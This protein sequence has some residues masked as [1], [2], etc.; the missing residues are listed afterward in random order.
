MFA[1]VTTMYIRPE[2]LDKAT[3]IFENSVLPAANSQKGY[4]GAKLLLDRKT[5]KGIVI[6]LWESE[7]DA[8]A[9]EENKYYEEQLLK[10]LVMFVADPIK[11]GFE[12]AV[13]DP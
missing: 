7:A 3:S 11:E 4:C 8:I 1:R 5:G 13:T 2:M 12:V 9:N 6:T 10:V